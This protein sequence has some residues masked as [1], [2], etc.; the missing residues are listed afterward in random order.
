MTAIIFSQ[1]SDTAIVATDGWIVIFGVQLMEYDEI[2]TPRPISAIPSE[3][4]K[5]I[6]L[7][8]NCPLQQEF[9]NLLI[10]LLNTAH[11]TQ[12]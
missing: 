2:N 7:L 8:H 3:K 1:L 12:T 9:M 5:L 11:N 4:G 10:R 6:T